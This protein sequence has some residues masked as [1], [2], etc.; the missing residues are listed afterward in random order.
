MLFFINAG[1]VAVEMT[2]E[3][4]ETIKL[5]LLLMVIFFTHKLQC[6]MA[7]NKDLKFLLHLMEVGEK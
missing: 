6:S 2:R 3:I 4:T 7:D 1:K 5:R